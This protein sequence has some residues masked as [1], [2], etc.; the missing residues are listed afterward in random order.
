MVE[1][2]DAADDAVLALIRHAVESG[3]FAVGPFPEQERPAWAD[4]LIR[5][6]NEADEK[7]YCP[8]FG[9]GAGPGYWMPLAPELVACPQCVGGLVSSIESRLGHSLSEEPS[10]CTICDALGPVRG[11]SIAVD[12]FLLRGDAVREMPG[13]RHATRRFAP[14]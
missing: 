10:R 2:K 13:G 7:R 11:V 12:R 9:T 14:R 3:G 6:F 4:E 8:H 1:H 5:Q